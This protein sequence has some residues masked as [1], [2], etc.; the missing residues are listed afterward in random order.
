MQDLIEELRAAG[1]LPE[2]WDDDLPLDWEWI[3]EQ[4]LRDVKLDFGDHLW[5]IRANG[6]LKFQYYRSDSG[7][8]DDRVIDLYDGEYHLP[9]ADAPKTRGQLRFLVNW[10]QC[11]TAAG[12]RMGLFTTAG[13][14]N[15]ARPFKEGEG[16]GA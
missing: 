2:N 14:V 7:Q 1:R 6:T 12:Y 5:L 4:G 15:A 16:P 13:P 10:L 8:Y 3:K 9:K 11:M